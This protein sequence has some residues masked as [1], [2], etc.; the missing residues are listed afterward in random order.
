MDTVLLSPLP[1]GSLSEG[2]NHKT[3]L[4]EV[5]CLSTPGAPSMSS[6]YST[7]SSICEAFSPTSDRSS[8]R[9]LLD[10][11]G[12]YGSEVPFDI[13]PQPVFGNGY[14]DSGAVAKAENV[15]YLGAYLS[16]GSMCTRPKRHLSDLEGFGYDFEDMPAS[17]L[18]HA[19]N[20]LSGPF[21]STYGDPLV[22]SELQPTAFGLATLANPT[23]SMPEVYDI[24]QCPME[25]PFSRKAPPPSLGTFPSGSYFGLSDSDSVAS[26]PLT[27]PVDALSSPELQSRQSGLGRQ[28]KGYFG[29]RGRQASL[30]RT[31]IQT[32]SADSD[33]HD[34]DGA[35][36]GPV[37]IKTVS[38]GGYRCEYI[39]CSKSFN[40]KEHLKRHITT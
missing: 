40:R 15:P 5:L 14:M 8:P 37:E 39:G 2:E 29:G 33:S 1:A 19:F 38:S 4:E 3:D 35:P 16:D 36:I 31:S 6:S 22:G 27:S 24:Q 30:R 25:S 17:T 18:A 21:T 12:S 28:D 23:V 20:P 11:N 34:E 9:G 7:C 32:S 26:Q 10:L 13:S